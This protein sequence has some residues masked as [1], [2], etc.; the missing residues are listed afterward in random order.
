VLGLLLEL[1]G[2]L[3]EVGSLRLELDRALLERLLLLDDERRLAERPTGEHG[4]RR[5]EQDELDEDRTEHEALEPLE[6]GRLPMREGE[7][8]DGRG[9]RQQADR[10]EPRRSPQQGENVL[11]AGYRRGACVHHDPGIS[12]PSPQRQPEHAK[13]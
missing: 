10:A 11:P 8:G 9:D 1:D 4:E 5:A 12:V 2:L 6:R 13:R 7:A 3:L